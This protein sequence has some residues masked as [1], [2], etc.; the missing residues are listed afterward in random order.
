M[1]Y[2]ETE[3]KG[4]YLVEIDRVGD[5]RGFFAYLF[6]GKQ[7]GE[8]GLKTTVAQIKLSY[9]RKRGTLRG[10]HM[11]MPPAAETKLVRCL[12]GAVFDVIVDC[13]PDSPTYLKHVAVELSADNRRALYVPEMFA[14]GYQTLTDDAEVMYQVD[15]FYSP[16]HERGLRWDDPKLAIAWPLPVGE[17]SPKDAV[18]PLL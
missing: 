10:L 9:N 5:D 16:R 17:L 12:R 8:L 3:L 2:L 6:E 15:E 4:A 11:Q 7:A 14:H 13:H 1:R 18:W